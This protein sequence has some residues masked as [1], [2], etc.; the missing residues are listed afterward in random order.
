MMD[1]HATRFTARPRGCRRV[2]RSVLVAGALGLGSLALASCGYS[3][4]GR[5]QFLPEYIR[6]VGIPQCVNQGSSIFD[7]DRVLTER[8]QRE[9][10]SH[11]H[12]KIQPDATGV[13][14]VLS[15]AI[16]SSTLT[17]TAFNSN[18]Q[19]SR[20]AV[21]IT[22]AI[23]FK[24]VKSD[25]VLWANPSMQ[26]REEYDVTTGTTANDPA[27]FFGQDQ[28]AL[29]RLAQTFG[30]TVVTSILEAF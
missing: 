16:K 7:I 27:A 8:V 2:L 6:I 20:Y 30:R 9:F 13:D 3:L 25:K 21:V 15:C 11:G 5:G 19:A 24:D 22:A 1:P 10:S 29:G 14:A 4:A 23:E 12:Y 18:N 17:P 26:V 28:N